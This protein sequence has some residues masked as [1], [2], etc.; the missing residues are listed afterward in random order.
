[1]SRLEELRL[2]AGE[3]RE[4]ARAADAALGELVASA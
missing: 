1:M 2:A 4:A 3:A